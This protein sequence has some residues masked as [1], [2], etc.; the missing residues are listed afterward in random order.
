MAWTIAFLSNRD[1]GAAIL[2]FFIVAGLAFAAPSPRRRMVNGVEVVETIVNGKV[3]PQWIV[4]GIIGLIVLVAFALSRWCIDRIWPPKEFDRLY[5]REGGGFVA[6]KGEDP[7]SPSP[8][9]YEV[10]S[11]SEETTA[12]EFLNAEPPPPMRVLMLGAE[13]ANREEADFERFLEDWIEFASFED[14][15]NLIPAAQELVAES[16]GDIDETVWQRL[17]DVHESRGF[18]ILVE[19][20]EFAKETG[21][22]GFQEAVAELSKSNA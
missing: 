5:E 16:D 11:F 7:D 6:W 18:P 2:T 19:L 8:F 3:V 20:S 4:V 17:L 9:D 1:R 10:P 21:D 14:L 22:V 13:K 15:E 12:R